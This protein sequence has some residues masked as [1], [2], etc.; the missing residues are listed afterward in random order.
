MSTCQR[1]HGFEEQLRIGDDGA[2]ILD[3]F[4]SRDYHIEKTLLAVDKRGIDR[5]FIHRTSEK[6]YSIE[7]KTDLEAAN[8]G[9]AFIEIVSVDATNTPGWAKSCLAQVLVLYIPDWHQGYWIRTLDIRARLKLWE[10]KYPV[11]SSK[12]ERYSSRGICV[13]LREIEVIA[14]RKFFIPDA[15]SAAD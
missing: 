2:S 9:N 14:R 10:G 1:V 15:R 12:N 6:S 5:V 8:T 7:Y 4:F 11:K 13:P 3:A